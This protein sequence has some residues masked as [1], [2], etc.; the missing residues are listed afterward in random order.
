MTTTCFCGSVRPFSDCCE[1]LIAGERQAA[2]AEELMRS[3]YSAYATTAVD[4]LLATTHASTR[5]QY[6]EEVLREWASSNTWQRLD[7][8]AFTET[9]VTFKAYYIDED[10]EPQVHSEHSTF[11]KED[12][13]WY[14]VDGE[15][16]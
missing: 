2:T 12:G 6:P 14:F 7:I 3:R 9:T 16:S 10:K 5:K 13:R 4:Y 8:S 11:R 15:V 1:P